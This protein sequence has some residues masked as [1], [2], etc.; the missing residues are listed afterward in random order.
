MKNSITTK[1]QPAKQ[2]KELKSPFNGSHP[3][4]RCPNRRSRGGIQ[5]R[6]TF[7]TTERKLVRSGVFA[8]VM[9][10]PHCHAFVKGVEDYTV[11]AT[12]FSI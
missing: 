6:H 10:C 3:D 5:L 12:L 1:T 11:T 7:K 9:T 2:G 4:S 8:T